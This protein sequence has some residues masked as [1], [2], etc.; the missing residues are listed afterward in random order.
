[1]GTWGTG[2]FDNDT[3]S[4]WSSDLVE[5]EDL[6]LVTETLRSAQ[7]VDDE[8]LDDDLR[9]EALAACEV[10]AR[11]QGRR[12][13]GAPDAVDAWIR[14]RRFA[15]TPQLV[16]LAAHVME[17]ITSTSDELAHLWSRDQAWRASL[18]DLRK[19]VAG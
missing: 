4:D 8:E 10:I 16:K 13:D 19:R 6:S 11:L 2:A 17:R 7:E 3:A 15:P 9:L 5:A 18:Q 1:M 14:S 12:R